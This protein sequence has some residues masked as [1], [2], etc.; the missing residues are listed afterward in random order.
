MDRALALLAWGLL[1]SMFAAA[2][3][4]M[5]LAWDVWSYHL[6]FAA[7]IA[8]IVPADRFGFDPLDQARFAGFP[9]LMETLQGAL[10]R[11]TGRPE[12]ANLV[13]FSAVPLFAWF[14]KRRFAVPFHFSVLALLAVPLVQIH[15]TSCYIDLP[16]NAAASVVVLLAADAWARPEPPTGRSLLLAGASAAI[17]INSKA[18]T[19][20][21]VLLA[22]L[23]IAARA[24]PPL[25]R[26]LREGRGTPARREGSRTLLAIALALP[27]VFATPA[28]NAVLHH[29]PYYP[30]KV[31]VLGAHLPGVE[32]PY[33]SSPAWLEHAARP[34]RFAASVVEIG[35]GPMTSTRRWTIDQWTPPSDPGY[36]MGGFF[37]AYV[38][39]NLALLAWRVVRDRREREVRAAA[40]GF[41]ALTAV[42][43]V[44]PQSHELRYYMCWMLV[45]VGTNLWLAARAPRRARA[46]GGQALAA[47]AA[48]AVVAFVTRGGY[49]YPSG[50]SFQTLVASHVDDA[51]LR[52]VRD[53]ERI[54][55]RHAPWNLLWAAPFHAPRSYAVTEAEDSTTCGDAP[56]L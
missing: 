22:L 41:A 7:R 8:G 31:D 16:A 56:S 53:G 13:A 29:N 3:H 37:G 24:L 36:R 5:S 46:L 19:H 38:I 23:A 20:P 28:K 27:V 34:A 33:S 4:D 40:A 43:S 47:T 30:E 35:L 50:E 25:V 52:G 54:C 9:L 15:A 12:S 42:V 6:P 11:V 44:M 10:W 18:L 17:A 51:A 48:L 1:A 39:A 49:L 14:L 26:G 55:V 45:L 32:E 2:L 21:I